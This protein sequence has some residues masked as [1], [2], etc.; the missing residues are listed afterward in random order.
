MSGEMT[1]ARAATRFRITSQSPSQASREIGSPAARF[2]GQPVGV[3]RLFCSSAVYL[4]LTVYREN[5]RTMYRVVP[6][7][8]TL[9]KRNI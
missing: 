7:H 4:G 1:E 2:R 6:N 5:A 8:Y 3:T 9:W